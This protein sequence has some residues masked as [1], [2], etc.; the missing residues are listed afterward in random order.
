MLHCMLYTL[1]SVYYNIQLTFISYFN[2]TSHRFVSQTYFVCQIF[3]F[4]ITATLAIAV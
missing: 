3:L 4:K 1:G 2:T